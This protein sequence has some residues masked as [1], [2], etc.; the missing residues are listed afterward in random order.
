MIDYWNRGLEFCT[1][2]YPFDNE[3]LKKYNIKDIEVEHGTNFI[4][5]SF[6]KKDSIIAEGIFLNKYQTILKCDKILPSAFICTENECELIKWES[7][8][9]L[10]KIEEEKCENF[11]FLISS[12]KVDFSKYKNT[13]IYY[14][15]NETYNDEILEQVLDQI[16]KK[17]K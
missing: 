1:F 12:D 17:T 11:S 4:E 2:D 15:L 10:A 14:N 16:N 6:K 13:I 3:K 9:L 7:L 8:D 5:V